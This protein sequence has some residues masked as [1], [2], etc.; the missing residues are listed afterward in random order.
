MPV[1]MAAESGAALELAERV[2]D[3]LISYLAGS[4]LSLALSR[5]D[6]PVEAAAQLAKVDSLVQVLGATLAFADW[7]AAARSEIALRAG[8]RAEALQ[9]AERAVAR[10]RAVRGLWTEGYAQRVWGQALAAL[11]P[12]QWDEAEAHMRE[13]L[14]LLDECGASLEAA[15]TH[16][17]WAMLRRVQGD[18]VAALEHLGHAA[19]QFEVSG[20]TSELAHARQLMSESQQT[21]RG[22]H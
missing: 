15:Q 9:L 21:L 8:N 14:R 6:R 1:C 16:M 4:G 3:R 20:I 12:P 22:G 18:A 19:R 7:F 13:S 5:L 17:A 11:D 10:A 2:H